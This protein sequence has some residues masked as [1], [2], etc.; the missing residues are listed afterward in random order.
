M[1]KSLFSLAVVRTNWEKK[2]KDH[3]ESYIPMVG[4]LLVEEKIG[5]VSGENLSDL[6]KRFKKRFGL[7]LPAGALTVI[8][9]RMSKE[10]YLTKGKIHGLPN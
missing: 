10:G 4:T 7:H 1:N 5:E 9:R 2:G 8:I 6:A 3:I